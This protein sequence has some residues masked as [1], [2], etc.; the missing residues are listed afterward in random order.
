[1]R[2]A[3]KRSGNVN[4][5]FSFLPL[6]FAY[7]IPFELFAVFGV[8]THTNKI[9]IILSLPFH[10]IVY[11]FVSI[12][13]RTNCKDCQRSKSVRLMI[14]TG[15]DRILYRHLTKSPPLLSYDIL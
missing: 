11:T 2:K 6:Q 5:I 1:M 10:T 7:I 12:L 15:T 8:N 3:I 13:V 9:S 4:I 14:Q